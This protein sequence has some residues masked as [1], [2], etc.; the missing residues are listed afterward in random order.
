VW[1]GVV[2]GGAAYENQDIFHEFRLR[3]GNKRPEE[4]MAKSRYCA[5]DFEGDA[6]TE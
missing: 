4:C 2:W 3:L 5:T 6:V 1:F